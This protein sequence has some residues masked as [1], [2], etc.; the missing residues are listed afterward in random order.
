MTARQSVYRSGGG[1]AVVLALA[2]LMQAAAPVRAETGAGIG[3]TVS[4]L[5]WCAS[6][7]S[8]PG[9]RS[10][11]YFDAAGNQRWLV[12]GQGLPMAGCRARMLPFPADRMLWFGPVPADAGPLEAGVGLQGSFEGLR[13]TV[14]DIQGLAPPAAATPGHSPLPL[15]VDL[16]PLLDVRPF[17]GEERVALERTGNRIA[18][19]CQPGARPAG[20]AFLQPGRSLPQVG[21]LSLEVRHRGDGGEWQLGLSDAVR[22]RREDPMLIGRLASG[23]ESAAFEIPLGDWAG[24]G[25][26]ATLLCP[27]RGGR[28]EVTE[29]RLTAPRPAAPPAPAATWAWRPAE[30]R[31]APG[32][33]LDRLARLKAGTVFITVPVGAVPVEAAGG[34]VQASDAPGDFTVQAPGPLGDFIAAARGRGVAVWAVM[35]DPHA[36]LPRERPRFQAWAR[37]YAA[38]NAAVPEARRLAG[39]QLD[40]EPYLI[41]GYALDPASWD[42]AY[43]D[44]VNGIAVAAGGLAVDLAVPFWFGAPDR[45]DRILD[46]L[47]EAITSLT[48]MD[49]RTSSEQVQEMATPFLSWGAER[50]RGIR[51][52]LEQ[53]LLPDETILN[54]RPAESG[55]LWRLS[56]EGGEALVLLSQ[57]ERGLRGAAFAEAWRSLAAGKS[58]TFHDAPDQLSEIIPKI[59]ATFAVWPSFIGLAIHGT[60]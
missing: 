20:L 48:V 21:G 54:F 43:A 57:P 11:V 27:E 59:Y 29:L 14:S 23:E 9:D 60:D 22:Q 17:G 41:P 1:Y 19:V 31:E 50:R 16:L 12:L 25:F 40:I 44:T 18:A 56:L 6:E 53:R 45:R 3:D 24:A 38:Y 8:N 55:T 10:R 28:L 46:R 42:A 7:P 13:F 26:S 37:A 47:S 2:V 52:A 33:L 58:Q 32:A 15:N 5:G 30:W 4:W 49:Y 36:V 51:V 35:G 39:L 34:A